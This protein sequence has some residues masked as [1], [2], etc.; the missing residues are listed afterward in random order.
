MIDVECHGVP[1]QACLG[2]SA[3]ARWYVWF[4]ADESACNLYRY[5]CNECLAYW[6]VARLEVY[7]ATLMANT[8]VRIFGPSWQKYAKLLEAAHEMSAL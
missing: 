6:F 4:A 1:A 2:G 8:D 7:Q 3:K 5:L